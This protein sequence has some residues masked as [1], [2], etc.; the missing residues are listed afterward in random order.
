MSVCVSSMFVLS[1]VGNGLATGWSPVQGVYQLSLRF[2][3]SELNLNG[4][5]SESVIRQGRKR[6]EVRGKR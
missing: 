4:N 3:V 5:R 2:T 6:E 1:C